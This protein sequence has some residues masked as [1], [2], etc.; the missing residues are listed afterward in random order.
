MFRHIF[1]SVILLYFSLHLHDPA[2]DATKSSATTLDARQLAQRRRRQ[3]SARVSCAT[4]AAETR[5]H[6]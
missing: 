1:L 6:I 5:E 3:A 4:A 2:R